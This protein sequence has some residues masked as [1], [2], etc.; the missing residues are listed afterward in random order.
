MLLDQNDQ[1][2]SD[3]TY[4]PRQSYRFRADGR[5]KVGSF[6]LAV[7]SPE[8]I[9]VVEPRAGSVVFRDEDLQIRWSGAIGSTFRIL[10]SSFDPKSNIPVKPL[11]EVGVKEGTN[12]IVLP[13]KILKGIQTGGGRFLFSVVSSNRIRTRIPGYPQDVLVQASSIHNVLL[14]LK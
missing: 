5:G 14:W 2:I 9:T 12:S 4:A 6:E 7:Q 8:E 13:A 10:I 3:F 11:L 1:P